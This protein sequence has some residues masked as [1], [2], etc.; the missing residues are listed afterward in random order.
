MRRRMHILTTPFCFC[1]QQL[2]TNFAKGTWVGFISRKFGTQKLGESVYAAIWQI[3]P[4]SLYL[5]F[6]FPNTCKWS[7]EMRQ[8]KMAETG[9]KL[10]PTNRFSLINFTFAI[11]FQLRKHWHEVI[12]K[13][14]METIRKI[15]N[16]K[17]PEVQISP[18][19]KLNRRYL[20]RRS[21]L[22]RSELLFPLISCTIPYLQAFLS[23]FPFSISL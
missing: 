2:F 3:A 1:V 10:A 7:L 16:F 19:V 14:L 11:Q 8:T 23:T 13:A 12:R 6:I 21:P 15:V 5:N 17:N 20:L 4:L 18:S 9:Q 22:L